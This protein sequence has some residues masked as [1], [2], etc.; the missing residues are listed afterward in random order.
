[1]LDVTIIQDDSVGLGRVDILINLATLAVGHDDHLLHHLQDRLLAAHF[2]A[3]AKHEL[4]KAGAALAHAFLI[5]AETTRATN[6][7]LGML[8]AIAS[9]VI[10][11]KML[12]AF[13]C[14]GLSAAVLLSAGGGLGHD[15]Q[16][17]QFSMETSGQ[18]GV[19]A[20]TGRPNRKSAFS[21]N[22]LF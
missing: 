17:A 21:L 11:L 10:L 9:R 18:V 5:N 6:A 13:W 16:P 12:A 15:R 2:R 8:Y 14:T 1:M 22:F 7:I 20:D 19:Q 4:L 3:L